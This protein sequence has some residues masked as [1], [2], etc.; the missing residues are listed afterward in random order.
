MAKRGRTTEERQAFA[1]SLVLHLGI[2]VMGWLST[3]YQPQPVE[4][5]TY[6]VELV[7]PP[8]AIQAEVQE[9]ATE[10][11][12]VERPE[13]TQPEPEPEPEPPPPP[14]EET[15]S[16]P[17]APPE[18]EEEAPDPDPAPEERSQPVADEEPTEATTT[19]EP[20]EDAAESGEDINVRLEGLRRDYP[21]YYDNII[22]QIQRCFRWQGSGSWETT[23]RFA[24][25]R[26][27]T[28]TDVEFASRSGNTA[29]DFEAMAA[30]ADCA[31]LGRFGP[32]PEDLP[33][34]RLPI[35]FSFRPV[36]MER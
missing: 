18:E 11:L 21:A 15:E 3:L 25:Q 31:G 26:D 5:I 16:A 10:E 27:G 33:Y 24:I 13:E 28:A 19:E 22:R 12:V 36:G 30:I 14:P 32:L 20:P 8:A 17:D 4:F 9:M 23:V 29:C 2:F 6:Q 35:Q 1:F 34:D 7:S